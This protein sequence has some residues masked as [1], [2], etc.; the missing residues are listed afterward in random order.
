MAGHARC[1]ESNPRPS[2]S[3]GILGYRLRTSP[4]CVCVCVCVCLCVFVC[5]CVC[6]CFVCVCACVCVLGTSFNLSS[7]W[8]TRCLSDR[9]AFRKN[10]QSSD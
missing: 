6:L 4:L 9:S 10:I 7:S 2:A 1:T 8:L 3:Q 5:V